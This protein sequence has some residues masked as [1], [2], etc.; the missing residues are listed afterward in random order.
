MSLVVPVLTAVPVLTVPGLTAH[1][2]APKI[3]VTP[4][5][6]VD[7]E[8]LRAL[9]TESE[10]PGARVQDASL[11][12]SP[13]LF[14]TEVTDGLNAPPPRPEVKVTL[15]DPVVL[16]AKRD[17][18]T[19]DLVGVT[20]AASDA[21]RDSVVSVRVRE[22]GGWTPWEALELEEDGPDASSAEARA[23]TRVGT[24]PPVSCFA[25]SSFPPS[26]S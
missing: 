2:V 3:S 19:F 22:D 25:S 12:V 15:P 11:A 13:A 5:Y 4:L 14:T 21:A 23:A 10:P 17:V 16:T 7:A 24:A 18:A 9:M 8:A 1:P 6:G 26:V 20:W